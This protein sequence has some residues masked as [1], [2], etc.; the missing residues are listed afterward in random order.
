MAILQVRN[1]DERL[2]ASL[3]EKAK[4]GNR[5]VSQE[6]ISILEQY[7]ANPA[8]IKENPTN[9][10]L[11]LSW[12]DERKAA[13]IISEIRGSRKNKKNYGSFDGLLNLFNN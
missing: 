7:L 1:I 6:V 2:Y 13:E 5:S 9:E 10:F 11:Q 8:R 4:K 3:K 12:Q